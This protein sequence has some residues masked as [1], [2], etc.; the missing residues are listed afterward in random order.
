MDVWTLNHHGNSILSSLTEI[1]QIRVL[2]SVDH[3]AKS[4]Q[5]SHLTYK[6]EAPN[7]DTVFTVEAYTLHK[8]KKNLATRLHPQLRNNPKT[9]TTKHVA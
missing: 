5:K 2:N 7:S 9:T 6:S 4:P 3:R 8:G 1:F